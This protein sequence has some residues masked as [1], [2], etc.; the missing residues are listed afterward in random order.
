MNNKRL[1]NQRFFWLLGIFIVICFGSDYTQAVIQTVTEPIGKLVRVWNI[2]GPLPF[3]I[4]PPILPDFTIPTTPVGELNYICAQW[5]PSELPQTVPCEINYPTTERILTQ[6]QHFVRMLGTPTSSSN[7]VWIMRSEYVRGKTPAQ[8]RDIFALPD[9]PI[10][11]VNVEMPASPDPITGKNYV[12][13]TGIAAPVRNKDPKYDWGDG[14]GVQNRLVADVPKPFVTVP[15][16][17][18]PDYMFTRPDTRI[19]RQP[20]GEIALSYRPLA[21]NGNAG[22]VAAY[23]DTFIPQAYSDLENV[24]HSL[25]YLNYV[26]FGPDPL[27][28]A[29]NQISPERY[30]AISFLNFRN[31]LLFGYTLLDANPHRRG[32]R[33]GLNPSEPGD[34]SK[35]KSKI[36][37]WI[38]GMGEFDS[39]TNESAYNKFNTKTGGI[40]ACVDI[41]A[42]P[43][44]FCGIGAAG[45]W[46]DISWRGLPGKAHGENVKVGFYA[47]YYPTSFFIDGAICAGA[48]WNSVSRN[49]NFYDINRQASGHPDGEDVEIHLQAGKT[50]FDT[51]APVL[52]CSYL[53]NWQ[54]HFK[55]SG[56]QSLNLHVKGFNTH[57]LRTYLGIDVNPVFD[58]NE[59][60]RVIPLMSVAWINDVSLNKRIIRAQIDGP[61]G[62]FSARGMNKEGSYGT[63]GVG[64]NV[65]FKNNWA[66]STRYDVEVRGDFI[67]QSVKLGA[68]VTF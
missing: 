16:N 55:E 28:D 9:Q 1:S 45:T 27:Q 58:I 3:V 14:G 52:R 39:K 20:I 61:E 48:D 22:G 47:S 11:I 36:N 63:W 34:D 37:L 50:F 26:D 12:L 43:H 66:L 25:D 60:V 18:F 19:H 6:P 15:T 40:F 13:W 49:I 17:Y 54:N 68:E 38:Q 10:A 29:L 5:D 56:A 31:A 30:G 53:F 7:G 46:N 4:Q 23:L 32:R 65:L 21:G 44:F 67:A 8:I 24:Y 2:N 42:R 57:T 33:L 59:S 62:S 41:E 64:G 35:K 51:V